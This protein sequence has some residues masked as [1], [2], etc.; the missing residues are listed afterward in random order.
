[1]DNNATMLLAGMYEEH[2][3]SALASGYRSESQG[4]QER[5]APGPYRSRRISATLARAR[6]CPPAMHGNEGHRL[7]Q[8]DGYGPAGFVRVPL[9]A[10]SREDGTTIIRCVTQRAV[11]LG[12]YCLPP[13]GAPPAIGANETLRVGGYG[14]CGSYRDDAPCG[15]QPT[16]ASSVG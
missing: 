14:P 12:C 2:R 6:R 1:M 11:P 5:R 8:S 15:R 7:Q 3:H 13:A 16:G 10:R 4:A 9:Y